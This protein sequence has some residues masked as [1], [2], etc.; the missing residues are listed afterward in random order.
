[1]NATSP[2]C[3]CTST[4]SS[5]QMALASR[6]T[7]RSTV[8]PSAKRTHSSMPACVGMSLRGSKPPPSRPTLENSRA[9]A[10]VAMSWLKKHL[11]SV[12]GTIFTASRRGVTA[13]RK[14][15][16]SSMPPGPVPHDHSHPPTRMRSSHA[17]LVSA[18]KKDFHDRPAP[19]D[20]S[21]S[22]PAKT[23]YRTPTA[24]HFAINSGWLCRR[25]SYTRCEETRPVPP[26][27]PSSAGFSQQKKTLLGQRGVCACS[28][29]KMRPPDLPSLV[30]QIRLEQRLRTAKDMD[31]S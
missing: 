18:W 24:S 7:L 12:P 6:S 31:R 13:R 19:L 3:H 2:A 29:W 25:R 14:S 5:S 17:S 8:E 22:G 15:G 28:W 23:V 11:R 26:P 27:S 1:M 20:A 16:P 4:A 21:W 9:F 10:T 30:V